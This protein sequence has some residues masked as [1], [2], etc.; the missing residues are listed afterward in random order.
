MTTPASRL[1]SDLNA[2]VERLGALVRELPIDFV[3]KRVGGV[4]VFITA[5]YRWKEPSPE[6]L[7]V[8]LEIKRDYEDWF[9]L[10][11]SVF[12]DAT[13]HINRRI[14]EG[15]ERLR[16]W[17]ELESNW[18]I[19][20]DPNANALKVRC[21]ASLLFDLLSVLDARGQMEPVV[22]PDTN[23]IVS[24]PEP[25]HYRA[26][27]CIDSFTFLLLPTVLGELDQ[28]K[29]NHRNPEFREKVRKVITRVK[30]WDHQGTL[31]E[32]VKLDKTITVRAAAREPKWSQT[33]SWLDG[34]NR[35][36]RI[37]ARVLEVQASYPNAQVVLVTGDINLSNKATLA[38]IETT[39]VV[40]SGAVVRQRSG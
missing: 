9:E 22:I 17:I 10:F 11:R 25:T 26:I 8:Q 35:D 28:L 40:K 5:K 16:R 32:G 7:G 19:Q 33:L 21:E 30:G 18:A 37:I 2:I 38:R 4:V 36:D 31:L 24:V 27:T 1:R 23:A 14:R 15:D 20:P 34:G 12:S 13:D 29:N 39:D 3:D 6:Q